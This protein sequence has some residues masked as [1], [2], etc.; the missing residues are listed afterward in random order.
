MGGAGQ[1]SV[2]RLVRTTGAARIGFGALVLV[3]SGTSRNRSRLTSDTCAA[4]VLGTRRAATTERQEGYL[5]ADT[6][7]R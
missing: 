3:G 5:E 1:R 4:S 7:A 6:D 2:S